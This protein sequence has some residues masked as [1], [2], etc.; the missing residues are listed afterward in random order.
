MTH[1]K[2]LTISW[3]TWKFENT[4]LC[5]IIKI[6]PVSSKFS[7]INWSGLNLYWPEVNLMLPMTFNLIACLKFSEKNQQKQTIESFFTT[8]CLLTDLNKNPWF[9]FQRSSIWGLQAKQKT[10]HRIQDYFRVWYGSIEVCKHVSIYSITVYEGISLLLT[11]KLLYYRS[12]S[13]LKGGYRG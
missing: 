4:Y 9:I 8:Y 12:K 13:S 7:L 11:C 2:F 3:V 10:W 6:R 1:I 5:K